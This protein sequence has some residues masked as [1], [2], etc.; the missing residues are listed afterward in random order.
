MTN[1]HITSLLIALLLASLTALHGA[2]S[3]NAGA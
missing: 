1:R 2:E 3:A